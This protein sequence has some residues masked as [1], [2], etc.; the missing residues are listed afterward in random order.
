M[1][2][3]PQFSI[4]EFTTLRGSFADDV[5][6]Y[7][8]VG[9]SGIGVCEFKLTDGDERR[10][11]DS[12]LRAN[13]CVPA[14]PSIL[15]LPL[16]P[17]PEDPAERITAL[18]A[19]IRRL[20]KLDPVAVMFFTGPGPERRNVVVEGIKRLADTADEAGV[21]LAIEPFHPSQRETFSFVNTIDEAQRL[22]ADADAEA[23]RL[24]FDTWQLGDAAGIEEQIA[25]H[26]WWFA[27]VHVADRREP[28]RTHFDRVVPGDGV[29]PLP[30]LL[31]AI[32]SAGYEGF[33]EVEIFSD[34]GSFGEALPDAL[35]ALPVDEA[36]RRVREGFDRVW[37]AAGVTAP[38]SDEPTLPAG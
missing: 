23:A 25:E 30:G 3:A 1:L 28:T 18:C 6:A 13:V 36:A 31:S 2:R 37:E 27:A 29:L 4:S 12:G 7:A 16:L 38:T 32:D 5:A 10:L 24:L 22:L 15:S 8:A 17:G 19:S 9:A 34:D 26:A 35:W 20:A 21:V 11:A 33:Y 14:V